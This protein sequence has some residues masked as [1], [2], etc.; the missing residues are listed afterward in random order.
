[1]KQMGYCGYFLIVQDFINWAKSHGVMVGPGRGSAAGSLA[2][3]AMGITEIDP[4]KYGLLFERF[5]NPERVSYPDIDTDFSK[6][7]RPKVIDYVRQKYGEAS[8]SKIIDISCLRSRVVIRD[9]SRVLGFPPSFGDKI[10]KAIPDDPKISLRGAMDNSQELQKMYQ[11]N[12]DVQK[13]WNIA[14]KLEGL[15]R[16]VSIH[17]CGTI[18]APS[19]VNNFLPQEIAKDRQTGERAWVTQY[20]GPQCEEMGLLK[21]DFLG[22]RTLDVISNTLELIKKT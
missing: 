3:Y 15:P 19:A 5:L 22:L 8:V 20:P 18:I 6:A 14:L 21:M 13:V 7:G 17:A 12:P 9:V 2:A 4:I 1:I 10:S 11:S 16:G